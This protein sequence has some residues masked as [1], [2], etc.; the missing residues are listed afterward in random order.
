M[1]SL[2]YSPDGKILASHA[3]DGTVRLWDAANGKE[4]HLFSDKPRQVS[5]SSD[6]RPVHTLAFSADG[7][8]LAGA[9]GKNIH[10]WDPATAKPIRSWPAPNDGV[11]SLSL[12]ADGKRLATTSSG[13]KAA[14]WDTDG[15][16]LLREC[17]VVNKAMEPYSF[18]L[19]TVALTPDGKTLAG[20]IRSFPHAARI[21]SDA[22]RTIAS[23]CLWDVPTGKEIGRVNVIHEFGVTNEVALTPDGKLMALRFADRTE[24]LHLAALPGGKVWKALGRPELGLPSALAFSADGR[25]LAVGFLPGPRK[26]GERPPTKDATVT[27]WEVAT[28]EIA[29]QRRGPGADV[30][31][32][33][34]APNGKTL[35]SAGKDT[36]ILMWDLA[37]PDDN[38]PKKLVQVDVEKLWTDLAATDVPVAYRAIWIMQGHADKSV[39]LLDTHLQLEPPLPDK[40][41][42]QLIADLDNETFAV[43]QKAEQKLRDF[44]KEVEPLL[45]A[46]LKTERP[47]ESER[48][49]RGL[50]DEIE[51]QQ[52]SPRQLRQARAIVVL[53]RIGDDASIKT[54]KRLAQGRSTSP[55]SIQALAA[56]QRLKQ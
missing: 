12:S 31:A 11:D 34:F 45:T 8:V 35:A 44:G 36:T 17:T 3:G 40:L 23:L 2:A 4:R 27:V 25:Y 28:G 47:L 22:T 33:A 53:E 21:L 29:W 37:P 56:L 30:Y 7:T 16:V 1:F 5:G 24:K 19:K 15:G 18:S 46:A 20:G 14:I 26:L 39:R 10:L 13:A 6:W 42:P 48:R 50:L 9:P 32:L 54:L 52:Y 43:R 55:Q 38:L 41:L 51:R 49:L